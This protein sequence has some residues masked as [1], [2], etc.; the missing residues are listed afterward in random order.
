MSKDEMLRIGG[1]F[2]ELESICQKSSVG[3]GTEPVWDGTLIGKTRKKP[4]VEMGVPED[5]KVIICMTFGVPE[6]KPLSKSRKRI[7]DFV[8]LNQHGEM[9]DQAQDKK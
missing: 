5:K 4:L 3:S 8:Y 9:W 6:G 1:L 7:E 2:E